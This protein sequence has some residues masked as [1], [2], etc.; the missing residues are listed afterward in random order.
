MRPVMRSSKRPGAPS[1]RN[2][3]H[4]LALIQR[5]LIH[6]AN[7][8]PPIAARRER[9]T[10]HILVDDAQLGPLF[11]ANSIKSD[12]EVSQGWFPKE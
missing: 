1:L 11:D 9:R 3:P 8:I 6:Y 2:A 5:S 12:L 10:N 4:V 7:S